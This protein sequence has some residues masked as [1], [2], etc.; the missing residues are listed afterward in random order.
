MKLD[1][2]SLLKVATIRQTSIVRSLLTYIKTDADLNYLAY[3]D[4]KQS[5]YHKSSHGGED[6]NSVVE[7]PRAGLL[8][9][10]VSQ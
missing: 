2:F 3:H 1:S 6:L 8:Y 10:T 9:E 4:T 7:L 5:S